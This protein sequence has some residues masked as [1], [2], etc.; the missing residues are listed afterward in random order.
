MK[1]K[2]IFLSVAMLGTLCALGGG[3]TTNAEDAPAEPSLTENFTFKEEFDYGDGSLIV[4]AGSNH[5]FTSVSTN[6]YTYGLEKDGDTEYFKAFVENETKANVASTN[7]VFRPNGGAGNVYAATGDN[8]D[9]VF[10]TRFKTSSQD[11]KFIRLYMAGKNYDIFNIF[12]NTVYYTI[13]NVVN[14]TEVDYEVFP[15][16]VSS[17]VWHELTVIIKENGAVVDGVSPDTI[18]AYLDG[19]FVYTKNFANGSDFTGTIGQLHYWFVAG[20]RTYDDWCIDYARIGEYN[21]P[22]ATA[23]VVRDVKV[24]VPFDLTPTF[25]GTNTEYL[26]SITPNFTV[27]FSLNGVNLTSETSNGM[28]VYKLNDEEIIGYDNGKY[29][30]LKSVDGLQATL[31]FDSDL[32]NSI[33]VAFDIAENEEEIPVTDIAMESV[34]QNNTIYLGLGDTTNET[35]EDRTE[36]ESLTLSKVF[37]ATPSTASNLELTYEVSDS[38]VISIE[39]GI[40]TGLKTGTATLTITAMGGTDV[41]KSITVHVVENDTYGLLNNYQVGDTWQA[42]TTQSQDNYRGKSYSGKDFAAISVVEDDLFGKAIKYTGN[43]SANASGSYLLMPIRGSHFATD[44]GTYILTGYVKADVTTGTTGRF[45]IKIYDYQRYQNSGGTYSYY[46]A[47]QNAP[48]YINTTI[49]LSAARDG[50]YYFESA[51]ISYDP[52]A[53]E[54]AFNGL[55]VEIGVYNT[56]AGVDFYVSNLKF[57][58]QESSTVNWD[59]I[60][61]EWNPIGGETISV[62]AGS[63]YQIYATP[64]PSYG[65]IKESYSSSDETLAT[66]DENGLVTFLNKAGSVTITVTNED[67]TTKKVTYEVKLVATSLTVPDGMEN[68]ELSIGDAFKTVDV[69]V[70]PAEATSTFTATAADSTICQVDFANGQIQ[71]VPLKVGTTTITLVANDN[72]EATITITIVIKGYTITFNANGH[73]EAP[74]ALTDVTAFPVEFT[75]LTAEGFVFGGWF[76]DADCTLVAEAG[77]AIEKDTILYAKWTVEGQET[78]KVTYNANGHGEAPAALT[79]VTA[80]PTTLPTLT[81]EGWKFEG[82]FLDADCTLAAEAGKEITSDTTLYAKWTEDVQV[83][84]DPEEPGTPEDPEQPTPETPKDSGVNVVAIVVPIVVVVVLAIAGVLVYFFVFK[85]KESNPKE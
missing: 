68:V 85:K 22:I 62:I 75:S 28:L 56:M 53:I 37:R 69:T 29:I 83:P 31:N 27:G 80:L 16:S 67:G 58:E 5:N 14:A 8:K 32:A 60:D 51:P 50:W 81:A 19:E 82:W 61:R 84:G 13:N 38:E 7:F 1:F 6:A 18:T 40:L 45:E 65:V 2:K 70:T 30:G 48:Y 73:G 66:V 10:K 24:G 71:I 79:D 64:I 77:T 26:P 35:E 21:A 15:K 49:N 12:N 76:L 9:V 44:G 33:A 20:Q 34:V 46:N 47:S 55:K 78:F 36:S 42:V 4:G 57:V 74:A 72:P 17:N 23:P 3:L 41:S 43:G 39:N 54:A 11:R 63:S 25:T 52:N 59:V